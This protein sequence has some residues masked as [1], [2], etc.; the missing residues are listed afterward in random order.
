MVKNLRDALHL[1]A[2]LPFRRNGADDGRAYYSVLDIGTEVAKALV[3]VVED[4]IGEVLGVGRQPQGHLDMQDGL[5]TDIQAVVENCHLALQQAETMAGVGGRDTIVGM[6]G[7]LT[8]GVATTVSVERPK[9]WEK[10]SVAEIEGVL[11]TVQKQA[12]E[13]VS[14]QLSWETGLPDIDVRLVNSAVVSVHI[15]GHAVSNPI[16]FQGRHLDV[17]VFNAFA[18]LVHVG[19]MHTIV[20]SL[21]LALLSVVAEPYAVASALSNRPALDYG[22]VVIDIGGGTTDVALLRGGGIE[23][24]KT[25][26]LGGR[27]FTKR[28]A[29]RRSLSFEEAEDLKLRYA[30]GELHPT[31]GAWVTDAL[32]TDVQTWMD[33]V[34]LLLEELAGEGQIPPYVYLCGGSS[35][36]PDLREVL[37][38]FDWTANLPLSRDAEVKGLTPGDIGA[39][40][41]KTGE[42]LDAQDV[43]PLGL[44]YQALALQRE[45]GVVSEALNHTVE[46]MG[47]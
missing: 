6:A 31:D 30:R 25:F 4:G 43:T 40:R 47:L 3:L 24:T 32:S 7:E 5:V 21:D 28:L 12:L 33:G 45:S 18:P 27:A 23:G 41:D 29:M 10:L 20:E 36:L 46:R 22:G 17:T 35:G 19:A 13:A 42:L 44:A 26:P 38:S 1:P 16:A 15:D 2:R 39:M 9:P 34:A 14:E 8:K 37:R 11:Q